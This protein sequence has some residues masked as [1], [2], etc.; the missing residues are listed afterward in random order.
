MSRPYHI[1]ILGGGAAGL[2]VAAGAASLGARVALVERAPH[3][4]GDCLHYGCVPSKSLIAAAKKLHT[5][6]MAAR[7]FGVNC[8]GDGNFMAAFDHVREVIEKLQQHDSLVR[9]QQLGV[10]IFQ[11]KGRIHSPRV[12]ETD[13]G[14]L[15]RGKSVVIATGSSPVIPSIQ[16]LNSVNYLTNESIFSITSLPKRLAILGGGPIGVEMAQAFARFGTQVTLLETRDQL[17]PHEDRDIV[18]DV[19]SV[20][21]RELVIMKQAQVTEISK[22]PDGAKSLKLLI[23][24]EPRTLIVDEVLV[25]VGRKPNT[26]NLGLEQL[27]MKMNGA[28]VSVDTRLRTSVPHHYAIGDVVEPY[29]FTH[30]AAMEAKVVI[31][32]AL[33]GLPRKVNYDH[34]PW[35][36]YTDPEIYHL[37]YTEQQARNRYGDRVK[38]YEVALSDVDRF[39]MGGEGSGRVKVITDHRGKI[40]G[41]HAAGQHAG[42][43]MQ[44]V[45]YAKMLGKPLS[46]LS[47]QI[48]PYPVR[49]MAVQQVADLVWREKLFSGMIQRLIRG[50]ISLFR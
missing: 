19:E 44:M 48:Y 28:Y 43:W 4:G 32:N 10:D 41:A 45:G 9:F 25:A 39:V 37:G 20:L 40:I 50:Y 35:V 34:V 14:H 29:P 17:L 36:V 18:R 7:Q 21:A 42:D 16:G 22:S 30:V 33:F 8:A 46:H 1:V 23:G 3:L 2:T 12:V 11:C 15:L 5:M 27:G 13:T 47:L 31:A 26:E 49:A 38:V 24:G 6:K